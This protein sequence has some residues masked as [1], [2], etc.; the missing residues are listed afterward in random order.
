MSLKEKTNRIYKAHARRRWKRPLWLRKL[1]RYCISTLGGITA[2]TILLWIL[3]GYVW[4]GWE[5]GVSVLAPTLGFELCLLVNYSAVRYFVWRDRQP[6]LWRYHLSNVSVFCVKMAFL[7]PIRYV[8]GVN[9]VLCNFVAMG[10]AGL[11]N[12]ILNDTVVFRKKRN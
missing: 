6:S 3:S 12:F 5:F 7:L 8:S 11:L 2:E 1:V 10:L 4:K 9:I